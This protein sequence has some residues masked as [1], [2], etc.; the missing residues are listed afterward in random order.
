MLAHG[1]PSQMREARRGQPCTA[2]KDRPLSPPACPTSRFAQTRPKAKPQQ[3][4]P[5]RS[6]SRSAP[7]PPPNTMPAKPPP[8]ARPSRSRWVRFE[9]RCRCISSRSCQQFATWAP[10]ERARARENLCHCVL[11]CERSG[12]SWVCLSVGTGV[13]TDEDRLVMDPI[14]INKI[15]LLLRI[16]APRL[17]ADQPV[18]YIHKQSAS[19]CGANCPSLPPLRQ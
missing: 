5:H 13:R 8:M 3:N 12:V 14:T 2:A 16:H 9:S 7:N 10:R 1:K 19:S 18:G 6:P 11:G 4:A 17:I 15:A